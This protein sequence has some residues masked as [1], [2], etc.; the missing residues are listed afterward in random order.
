MGYF[1]CRPAIGFATLSTHLLRVLMYSLSD[2]LSSIKIRPGI[3][4]LAL[5]AIE[6]QFDLQES[7]RFSFNHRNKMKKLYVSISF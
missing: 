1:S 5:V 3:N 2:G 6:C 7:N 4:E